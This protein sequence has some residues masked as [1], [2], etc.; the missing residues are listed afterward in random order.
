[1]TNPLLTKI[2]ECEKEFEN[3]FKDSFSGGDMHSWER[4]EPILDW[5]K[6]SFISILEANIERL[7][8]KLKNEYPRPGK[9]IEECRLEEAS[10]YNE[11]IN[12]EIAFYQQTLNELNK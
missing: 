9:P 8:G 6:Q 3:E 5:H 11:V 2:Q 4:A 7:K 1:M 10:S 12:E